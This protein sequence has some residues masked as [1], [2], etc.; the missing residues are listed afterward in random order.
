MHEA[1]RGHVDTN[2]NKEAVEFGI[3]L[4]DA[5]FCWAESKAQGCYH[6]IAGLSFSVYNHQDLE[7]DEK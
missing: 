3:V 1:L 7:K 5:L 2:Y 6:A 4:P